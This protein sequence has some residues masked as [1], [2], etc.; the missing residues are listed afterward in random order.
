PDSVTSIGDSAFYNCSKI[1]SVTIGNGVTNIGEWAF[2]Y[3]SSLTSINIPD[4][5][6]NIERYAF[7]G[8]SN[9]ASVT[10]EDPNGWWRST[11]STATSGTSFLSSSLSNPSTAAMYLRSS[12]RDYYWRKG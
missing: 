10:F 5:V 9:L 3:C 8:C 1:T 12:Y 2:A 6:R 4:S 11:S 7:Y